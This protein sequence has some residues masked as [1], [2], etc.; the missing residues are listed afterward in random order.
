MP[1]KSLLHQIIISEFINQICNIVQ[2]FLIQFASNVNFWVPGVTPGLL[3]RIH[4]LEEA[5]AT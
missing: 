1:S 4:Q 5:T 2:M 3:S